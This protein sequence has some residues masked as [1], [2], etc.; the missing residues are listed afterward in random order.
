MSVSTIVPAAARTSLHAAP[1]QALAAIESA[2]MVLA[3]DPSGVIIDAN[4]NYCRAAGYA[5]GELNGRPLSI[6]LDTRT[7]AA[8]ALAD[9]MSKLRGGSSVYAAMNRRRKDGTP[10]SL[11]AVYLPLMDADGRLT[12][13]VAYATDTTQV[14]RALQDA[15]SK[16]NALS[17]SQAIIQFTP[18]GEVTW[19]NENF[20]RLLGYTLDEIKG[21]HHRIFCTPEYA[22]SPE[23]R[24]FWAELSGGGFRQVRDR[25]LTKTGGE[26]WIVGSYN[27]L[28]DEDGNVTGVIKFA[29]DMTARQN[30]TDA[31]I[32]A[33]EGLAQGDL[34]TR[35]PD[36]VPADFMSVRDRFN[37]T[38]SALET[39][40]DDIRERSDAM[41]GEAGEI[42]RGASEISRRGESQAAALE[43]TAA[44]VEEISG[45]ITMTSEAARDADAA[46]RN[47]LNVVLKGAEVVG[48]AIAAIERIDEHTKQMGEFTRV[49]EGFAFQTNLLSIN[50]AVEAARAG[51]VGRGFAVVA[52]EVRNLAQQ[53]AKAS[54][55]IAELIG[56]SET[57]VKAG[58]K[59]VRDAG[60]SLDQIQGAVGGVVEN[61]TGIAHATTEQSQGVREVSEALSQLDGVNQANLAM[62]E[63]FA[64]SSAGLSSQVEELSGMMERFRTATD[65][66]ASASTARSTGRHAA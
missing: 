2:M 10:F 38:T 23:Y 18:R 7:D 61:I 3:F 49:I 19:A 15:Q 45:N 12:G 17:R 36:Q 47:A 42:A 35:M 25:R 26:V 54:Q 29:T 14:Q 6:L 41:N 63:Q 48:Q 58:V 32:N 30:A 24:E 37:H 4:D 59:L 66:A 46:A 11:Q 1:E 20:L 22:A 8:A 62:S 57:E 50:A 55:N 65:N 31:L 9:V 56:K 16:Q 13:A 39:M 34:T 53:S 33:L 21:Q 5:P 44:A 28:L 51:E 64:A 52:N 40:V 43:E 27:A 60:V